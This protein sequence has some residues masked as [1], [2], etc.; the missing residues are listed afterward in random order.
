MEQ[1]LQMLKDSL[2]LSDTQAVQIKSILDK[3]QK[4]MQKDREAN[5]DDRDAMRAAMTKNTEKTDA[6]IAKLLTPEQKKKYEEMQAQRRK[7][8]QERMRNRE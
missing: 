1:R 7:Q 6:E 8:M 2:T 4:Q 3:S 5:Q